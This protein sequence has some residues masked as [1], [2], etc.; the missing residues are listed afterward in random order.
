MVTRIYFIGHED[1]LKV[2]QTP[3]QVAEAF[4]G[5]SIAKLTVG[6]SAVYVNVATVAYWHQAEART[7]RPMA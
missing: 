7:W 3:E 1:P 6:D 5:G 4:E 2:D